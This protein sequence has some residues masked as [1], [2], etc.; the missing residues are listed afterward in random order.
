MVAT[1][2]IAHRYLHGDGV[3]DLAEPLRRSLSRLLGHH[4]ARD[5]LNE[6]E[7]GPLSLPMCRRGHAAHPARA[8][9]Q[10]DDAQIEGPSLPCCVPASGAP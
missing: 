5:I 4:E 8:A 1:V 9:P 7:E 2:G 6:G 3:D 10:V